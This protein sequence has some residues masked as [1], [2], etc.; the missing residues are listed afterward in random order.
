MHFLFNH[1]IVPNIRLPIPT[2]SIL[3]HWIELDGS[4]V[5]IRGSSS[6][7]I[8]RKRIFIV[9]SVKYTLTIKRLIFVVART[10]ASFRIDIHLRSMPT[11]TPKQTGFGAY[12]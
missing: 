4:G 6:K 2:G 1:T 11:R 12:H 3:G 10:V 9:V 8:E 5:S 7:S